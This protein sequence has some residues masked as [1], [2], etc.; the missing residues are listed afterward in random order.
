M[1]TARRSNPVPQLSCVGG[2]AAGRSEMYP[3]VVQCQNVGIDSFGEVQWK[4]EA[5]LDSKVR[6]ANIQVVCEG[7]SFPEDRYIL[8]GSC[9]LEYSLE[10]TDSGKQ[11]QS[12]SRHN[13]WDY[14]HRS[15]QYQHSEGGFFS[16]LVSLIILGVVIFII[17][18][19]VR[20]INNN[21]GDPSSAG[22]RFPPGPGF[23]PGPGYP[24]YPS[25][26]SSYGSSYGYGPATSPGFFGGLAGGATLGY[27]FGRNRTSPY[28]A[29][30][31]SYGYRGW[32]SSGSFSAPSTGFGGG[33]TTRTATGFGGTKKR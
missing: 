9:G 33:S 17:I 23:G 5:D 11:S 7:Y 28:Y 19:I 32:G 4:C 2:S 29:A 21:L 30:P 1:S 24:T 16:S 6:F 15:T 31:T 18:T 3:D 12:Y 20:S 14:N 10:Y 26:P 8:A 13:N 22:A 27:L 25:Y